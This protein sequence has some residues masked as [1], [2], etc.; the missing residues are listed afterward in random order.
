[1]MD[2]P[3]AVWPVQ[4]AGYDAATKRK[5]CVRDATSGT[6]LESLTLPE[7]SQTRNTQRRVPLTGNCPDRA[8]QTRGTSVAA[9]EGGELRDFLLGG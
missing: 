9:L 1:M 6:S 7:R 2:K 8:T 3:K 5:A 4:A